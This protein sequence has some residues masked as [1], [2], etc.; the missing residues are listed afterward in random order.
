M[1]AVIVAAGTSSRLRPLTDAVHKT[2]LPVGTKTI[3][4]RLVGNLLQCGIRDLVVV[5]GYRA[6][7][8]RA[9]LAGRDDLSVSFVHNS[10]FAETNNAYSLFLAR[11]EIGDEPFILLDSDIVFDPAIL[12]RLLDSPQPDALVLRTTGEI[13][14]EEIK[15]ALDG[16]GRVERIGKDV[17]RG[18]AKGESIGIEKFGSAGPALFNALQRRVEEGNGRNEFYE[19]AFQEIIDAGIPLGTVDTENLPSMEID[20]LDDLA[21][22]RQVVHRWFKDDG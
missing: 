8:L 17:P 10:E 21:V 3:L 2:L 5:T 14:D 13:G 1:K 9:A 15:V 18:E 22:A 6:D 20:T 19:A 7:Q 11:R 12:R 16:A 4:D